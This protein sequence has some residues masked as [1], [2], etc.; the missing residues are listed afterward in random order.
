MRLGAC[1]CVR[2]RGLVAL[3]RFVVRCRASVV[4]AF[5][6]LFLMEWPE[7][8]SVCAVSDAFR[9]VRLRAFAW[10][11]C[12]GEVRRALPYIGCRSVLPT[13]FDGVAGGQLR[14]N[15]KRCVW[16]VRLRAFA[17]V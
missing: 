12:V 3:A 5:F 4:G 14:L 2:L 10:V 16:G 1:V 13:V 8:R 7:A 6:R 11:S 15:R 9:G 17:W